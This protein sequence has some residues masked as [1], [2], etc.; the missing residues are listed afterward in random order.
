MLLLWRTTGSKD[1][2]SCHAAHVRPVPFQ[3]HGHLPEILRNKR[4]LKRRHI[5]RRAE[6][7]G[8]RWIVCNIGCM[9]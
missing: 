6:T 9:A 1:H 3:G 5:H 7:E 2:W 4:L 8:I